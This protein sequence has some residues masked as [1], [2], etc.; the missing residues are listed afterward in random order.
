ME[1]TKKEVQDII[2]GYL[3]KNP[4]TQIASI[5]G[6]VRNVLE[7][8]GLIGTITEERLGVTRTYKKYISDEDALLVNEVIYD[9]LYGRVITPGI[10]E[11]NQD[12]PWVHVSDMKKLQNYK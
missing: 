9:L 12:L 7:E 6:S 11:S 1:F 3:K 5:K 8:R 4:K 10:N 2:I